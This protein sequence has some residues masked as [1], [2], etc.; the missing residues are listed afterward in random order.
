M[1]TTTLTPADFDSEIARP[2]I[3]K[4]EILWGAP[5]IA[6]ACGLSED[7]IKRLAH[8]EGVPIYRPPGAGMYRADRSTL[9][10]WL[11]TKPTTH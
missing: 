8:V 7:T 4:P 6:R 1:N 11:R 2:I 3:R 9:E 10:R 5:A